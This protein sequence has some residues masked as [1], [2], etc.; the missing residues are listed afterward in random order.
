[1]QNHR[2]SYG[3][4]RNSFWFYKYPVMLNNALS[5]QGIKV[6]N[7]GHCTRSKTVYCISWV[8]I[9]S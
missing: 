8:Y 1:M 6:H 9:S 2:Q 5:Y 3:N 7:N 4:K